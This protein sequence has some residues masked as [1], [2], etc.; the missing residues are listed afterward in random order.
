MEVSN[1]IEIIINNN[2]I[3]NITNKETPNTF[4]L[5]YCILCEKE[6]NYEQAL[7]HLEKSKNNHTNNS[8]IS[9]EIINLQGN[10]I[11][12]NIQQCFEKRRKE[13]VSEKLE[14]D[15]ILQKM[16]EFLMYFHRNFNL[17][18]NEYQKLWKELNEDLLKNEKHKKN[19]ILFLNKRVC[20][21]KDKYTKFKDFNS[22]ASQ[23]NNA[24]FD[25]KPYKMIKD[26]I[27]TKRKEIY[28][29]FV[30]IFNCGDNNNYLEK[31]FDKYSNDIT[32][33]NGLNKLNVRELKILNKK[34]GDY[35]ETENCMNYEFYEINSEKNNFLNIKR[36]RN[37]NV[38]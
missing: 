11:A 14:L 8:I 25:K 22:M 16:S 24:Y 9:E 4:P 21:L 32:L 31:T 5:F 33:K 35:Y 7:E 34:L 15:T 29:K 3:S 18:K 19:V 28:Q 37:L 20:D 23:I 30:S 38:K 13:I 27:Q 12:N 17:L 1:N 26:K 36:K 2:A 10:S 6:F